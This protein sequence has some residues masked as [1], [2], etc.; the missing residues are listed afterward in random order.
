MR[1][2]LPTEQSSDALSTHMQSKID[3]HSISVPKIRPC[4]YAAACARSKLSHC[5]TVSLACIDQPRYLENM[6]QD[7]HVDAEP[8]MAHS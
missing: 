2:K 4:K 7:R 6:S 5:D 1:L 3:Q 8:P